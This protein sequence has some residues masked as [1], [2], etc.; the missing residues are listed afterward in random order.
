VESLDES[1][2]VGM[3]SLY[4]GNSLQVFRA[5]TMATESGRGIGMVLAACLPAMPQAVAD[6]TRALEAQHAVLSVGTRRER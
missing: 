1:R 6:A 3:G 2:R 4:P 5:L